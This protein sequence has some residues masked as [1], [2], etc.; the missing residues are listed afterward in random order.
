[1]KTYLTT[2]AALGAV[3]ILALSAVA[4][5]SARAAGLDE[6]EVQLAIAAPAP[7]GSTEWSAELHNPTEGDL[8]LE[9]TTR[10]GEELARLGEDLSLAIAEASTGRQVLVS[11]PLTELRDRPHPLVLSVPPGGHVPIIATLSLSTQAGNE[12][13]GVSTELSLIFTA[14]ID[15]GEA[16]SNGVWGDSDLAQTGRDIA[17]IAA[18]ALGLLALG[19]IAAGIRRRKGK[20]HV[21]TTAG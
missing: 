21:D 14:P 19:G 11:T 16:A 13:Q 6:Q 7:G 10:G 18:L 4:P 17:P 12:Y 5:A 3:A 1:M 8:R 2:L 9:L 15:D 20:S